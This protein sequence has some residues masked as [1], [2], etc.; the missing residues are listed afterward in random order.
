MRAALYIRVSTDDQAREGFSLDA[1]EKR[2]VAYCKVRG[3]EVSDIY[4]DEGCSGRV[5]VRP[6]YERMMSEHECWDVL[7]VLKMD[8]IHRNSVNFTFMMDT[9]RKKGKEFMSVQEKF[10]T[11]TAM[12]RFVMDITQRIAQLESEQIGERVKIGM[13]RKA[14]NGIGNMGSGHPYG[15]VY[16]KG[17]L[18]VVEEEAAVVRKIFSMRV[19][20]LSLRNISYS[21]NSSHLMPK[22]GTEWS[23]QAVNN[24]LHNPVYAGYIRWDGFVRSGEHEAIVDK[25]AFER[26]NGLLQK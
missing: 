1:Q 14:K 23:A 2:L 26:L 24:I 20:G 16:D 8:R 10:D 12:G 22:R 18:A 19:E 21:L 17:S 4:R 13:A 9:L 6:E 15:Y 7:L 5:I 25:E 3:W 11:T